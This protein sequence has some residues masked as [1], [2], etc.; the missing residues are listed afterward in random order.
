MKI[1]GV[2]MSH[3][4]IRGIIIGLPILGLIGLGGVAAAAT[5]SISN[6]GPNSSNSVKVGPSESSVNITNANDITI[7]LTAKLQNLVKPLLAATLVEDRPYLATLAIQTI[8]TL[9][10]L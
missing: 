9:L 10:L 2:F 8:V 3:K 4:T 7:T 5:G 6:T 1:N